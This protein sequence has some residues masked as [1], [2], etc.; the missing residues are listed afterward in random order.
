MMEKSRTKLFEPC[1]FG[2]ITL[3]N[4][5]VMAPL[6]RNRAAPGNIPSRLAVEYYAQRASAGL[7]VTEATQVS[8]D[9]QG[10]QATPGIH[11]RDQIEGWKSVTKAVHARGGHIVL[12]LWHVGRVSHVS[13][14]PD[15]QAPVAPSAIRART[16]TSIGGEFVDVSEPRA[17]LRDELP[18]IVARFRQAARNAIAAG[19]DGVEIHAANG[20]LL[21]QFL[22]DSSNIRT[23]DYGGS[24]ENRSKL[25]LEVA[26]AVVAE[27]GAERT[28][29]RISPV[30]PS[31]DIADSDPQP[32]F[33]YLVGEFDK[34][35]L[36]YLHVVEGAA[37]GA[38]DARPF[39]Y[40]ALRARFRRTYLANNGYT[41]ALAND[42]IA[43]GR[44]D[45]ISFGKLFISNPDLVERLQ[46]GA[47]LAEPDKATFY[48][49]GAK[50]YTNYP[51]LEAIT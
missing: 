14:Q 12:Q 20:Y 18:G 49:G 1:Q 39:D 29:I 5:I 25:T 46:R 34:L 11:S 48:S 28:G 4:R 47:A 13:L 36:Q 27:I 45:L 17:L 22:R 50:G 40:A 6:T 30:N 23:D 38:R 35:D 3:P 9:G 42:A 51:T 7:I 16:K 37:G 43:A 10:Y 26:R 15:G 21:D 32:L 31:N 24:V 19:F 33:N 44:A 41:F 8:P 2:K